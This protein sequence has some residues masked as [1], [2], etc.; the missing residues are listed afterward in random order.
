MSM[1]S[2]FEIIN[3]MELKLNVTRCLPN[4]FSKPAGS[5]ARIVHLL[6]HSAYT[7]S[8]PIMGPVGPMDMAM[9]KTPSAVLRGGAM[10]KIEVGDVMRNA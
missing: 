7:Y 8:A 9:S 3:H 10:K 1:A 6:I 4:H 2:L 5:R